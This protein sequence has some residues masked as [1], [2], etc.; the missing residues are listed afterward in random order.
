MSSRSET[1]FAWVW[2]INGLLVLAV[3]LVV[4]FAVFGSTSFFGSE[5]RPAKIEVAGTEV[6]ADDLHLGQFQTVAGTDFLYAKLETSSRYGGSFGSGA[7]EGTRNILFFDST[8]NRSHWLLAGN[9][10]LISTF[11]FLVSRDQP[12]PTKDSKDKAVA[13]IFDLLAPVTLTN[14]AAKHTRRLAIASPDGRDLTTLVDSID[15]FL[16][17][18]QLS[19]STVVLFYVS[20]G[21]AKALNYDF[22]AHKVV[23]DAKLTAE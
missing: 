19:D 6:G 16:G 7:E 17:Y 14:E 23:S 18:H 12:V 2:R 4:A 13:I 20:G 3:I 21:S 11:D 5:R 15:D 1:F 10:Q 22:A 9:D 8:N